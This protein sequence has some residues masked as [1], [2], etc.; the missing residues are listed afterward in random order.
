MSRT[1]ACLPG[2]VL[3][4]V[5][6]D[7]DPMLRDSAAS[8]RATNR[9][10]CQ[11]SYWNTGVGNPWRRSSCF[12]FVSIA[13]SGDAGQGIEASDK[14]SQHADAVA[15]PLPFAL[16]ELFEQRRSSSA[17]G[18]ARGR[19]PSRP[20]SRGPRRRGR[21]ASARSRRSGCRRRRRCRQASSEQG[22]VHDEAVGLGALPAVTRDLDEVGATT[23][24][25]PELCRRPVR[26]HGESLCTPARSEQV[27]P[28]GSRGAT[29]SCRRRWRTEPASDRSAPGNARCVAA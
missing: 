6:L 8:T 24:E 10:L 22:L 5:V 16:H 23:R 3:V 12:S 17:S 9:P 18:G 15:P 7:R 19:A 28:P 1:I 11:I 21:A 2:V 14:R 4:A 29:R 25:V 13:L 20:S 26:R 27:A